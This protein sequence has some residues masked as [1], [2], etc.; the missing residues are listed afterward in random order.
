MKNVFVTVVGVS[1]F[2]CMALL[3][4]AIIPAGYVVEWGYNPVRAEGLGAFTQSTG[5]V[6]IANQ[7]LSNVVAIAAGKYHGLALKNDGTVVGWGWNASGRAIGIPSAVQNTNG[8]VMIGGQV[9]SNVV[10]ISAYQFSV[11]IKSDGTT[12]VWGQSGSGR[13]I[14]V[15]ADLTNAVAVASGEDHFLVLKRDGVVEILSDQPARKVLGS[16]VVVMAAGRIGGTGAVSRPGNDLA[17]RS[18]GTLVSYNLK[19]VEQSPFPSHLTN[20]T[21]LISTG[22]SQFALTTDGKVFGSGIND[23]GQTTGMPTTNYI[24]SGYVNEKGRVLEDIIAIASGGEANLAL[25]ADG[26]LFAWGSG[27]QAQVPEGLSNVVAIAAGP[28]YC[29]AITTNREV[30]NRFMPKDK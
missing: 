28:S 2:S 18:D 21:A 27:V 11:A 4:A 7:V 9:L 20:I 6:V 29:L 10:A 24:A 16:N 26:T 17:V 1:S 25:K 8:G 14:N 19:G 13:K 5:T 30:A 22:V 23:R 3:G 12:A 15:P